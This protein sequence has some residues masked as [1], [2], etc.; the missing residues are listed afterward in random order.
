[1]LAFWMEWEL[2]KD[3]ILA[4]YLNRVYLGGGA[5]GVDAASKLYFNK[6]VADITL[7]EAATLAGLLKAPSTYS[8]IANPQKSR[9]RTQV[10]LNAMVDAGHLDEEHKKHKK[11]TI[12]TPRKK[13]SGN[14]QKYY[15]DWIVDEVNKLIGNPEEDLI[16]ETTMNIDSQ[17]H[18]QDLLSSTLRKTG[19]NKKI[20]QGSIVVMRPN[21]AVVALVGGKDY[22]QSQFN[23]ATQAQRQPG[24]SFKPFTYLA[25]LEAGW[26]PEDLVMDEEIKEGRYRPKNFGHKYYGEVTIEEA[27][28]LSLNTIAFQL[29]K[30]IG[31]QAVIDVA[32]R[33][34]VESEMNADLSLA[35]GT[36]LISPLELTGAYASIANGG[37]MVKPWGIT[38]ITTK[39]GTV[40]YERKERI[41]DKRVVNPRAIGM[42]QSMMGS[43]IQHGTGQNANFGSTKAAGKTGTSQDNRDAWFIGF[44]DR[45]VTSVWLGNDNNSSMR[46][47][48][49]GAE[50]AKLW[51]QVMAKNNS[52]FAPFRFDIP[53]YD[54]FESIE[55]LLFS[56]GSFGFGDTERGARYND[57]SSPEGR[58]GNGRFGAN[59]IETIRNDEP[60]R[61]ERGNSRQRDAIP[62][63]G[64]YND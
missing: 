35:L 9:E 38:K 26:R 54:R 59:R 20:S 3:E 60:S 64:R 32:Q 45:L 40:Y 41:R 29:I 44:T 22:N 31:P 15:S 36:N 6:P 2:T 50:P 43:V 25:A 17:N 58:M 1:M 34:G 56:W 18:A 13:P 30:D 12:P 27:L 33:L 49:G 61:Y 48:T 55:S 16:I 63:R 8:P 4:A 10:V 53:A 62:D 23:R 14:A 37:V 21:G 47:V 7:E 51:R 28:T 57:S 19:E 39:S 42:L 52:K 46:Y 11:Y 5:F 24:S